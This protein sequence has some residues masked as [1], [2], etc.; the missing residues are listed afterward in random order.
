LVS[1]AGTRLFS[2]CVHRVFAR[3]VRFVG[4]T[5]RSPRGRPRRHDPRHSF[6]VRTLLD[7]HGAGGDVQA[8]LP[9]PSTYMGHVNPASTYCYLTAAPELLALA[10]R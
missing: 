7:W 9:S 3:L 10:A 5:P 4:L 1:T 8:Q 2:S 6:A